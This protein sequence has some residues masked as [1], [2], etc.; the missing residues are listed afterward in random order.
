MIH[1]VKQLK[2]KIKQNIKVPNGK[3]LEKW[4]TI[5]MTGDVQMAWQGLK[6]MMGRQPK[7]HQIQCSDHVH[8]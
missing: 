6:S 5:M 4:R 8:F 3:I 7:Q 1:T 2:K